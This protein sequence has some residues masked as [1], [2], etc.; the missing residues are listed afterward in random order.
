[1]RRAR[2]GKTGQNRSTQ[3]PSRNVLL[4]LFVLALASLSCISIQMQLFFTEEGKDS[5]VAYITLTM[6]DALAH[7]DSNPANKIVSDLQ[8]QGWLFVESKSVGGGKVAVTAHKP[9]G[10]DNA[11]LQD[12]LPGATF[13]VEEANDPAKAGS[14]LYIFQADLDQSQ[15]DQLW[16]MM[17]KGSQQ[18]IS[19]DPGKFGVPG[20]IQAY[21][22]EEV[23]AIINTFG[24]PTY[25]LE[26]KMPGN[27]PVD[28]GP[29]WKNGNTWMSG[30]EPILVYAWKP[31]NPIQASLT[32]AK[33]YL[34]E[35]A[36]PPENPA[37]DNQS[38]G[39]NAGQ[40][41]AGAESGDGAASGNEA[42]SEQPATLGSAF[43]ELLIY[44]DLTLLEQM[45]G[46]SQLNLD[47]QAA[48]TTLADSLIEISETQQAALNQDRANLLQEQRVQAQLELAVSEHYQNLQQIYQV[49]NRER[50][51][52]TGGDQ[53]S[54]L[55]DRVHDLQRLNTRS[56]KTLS[57]VIKWYQNPADYYTSQVQDKAKDVAFGGKTYEEA[58]QEILKETE[59]LG[60][61]PAIVHYGFYAQ[62]YQQALSTSGDPAQAHQ[63]AMEMLRQALAN[64]SDDLI[65]GDRNGWR[66]FTAWDAHYL[67]Y[68]AQPGGIYDRAF[69]QLGG[70]YDPGVSR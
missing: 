20:E 34:P 60:N 52:E 67:N 27:T 19:V 62:A 2:F 69:Q 66:L 65:A 31:G 9:F 53:A 7:S 1:M 33:R 50:L 35:A 17:Q 8:K 56:I 55:A 44:Q 57:E 42:S 3:Q 63:Q 45:P 54:W 6:P 4:C 32:A 41:A 39:E 30:T 25:R 70:R 59:R 13:T 43:L 26:L 48:L 14:Y 58:L 37:G 61:A 64:P 49:I 18:G 47:Q 10:G 28:A 21:S 22:A 11:P 38:G 51:R 46:W 68:E 12:I 24:P 23:Q 29:A 5:G 16:Q 15:L 36:S 40:E